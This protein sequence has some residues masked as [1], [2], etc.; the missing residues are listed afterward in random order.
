MT[1]RDA[2][3]QVAHDLRA[4][5][6]SIDA[7]IEPSRVPAAAPSGFIR[8]EDAQPTQGPGRP[9]QRS[10]APPADPDFDREVC[11]KHGTAWEPGT[12]GPYCKQRTDDPAWGKEKVDRDGNKVLWCKLTPRNAPQWL[13]VHGLA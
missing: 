12:Y 10:S 7:A 4:L 1:A 2:W 13:K 6:D 8:E 3:G 11:P 9:P 5:A